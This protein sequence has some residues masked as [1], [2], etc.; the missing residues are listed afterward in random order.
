MIKLT[1]ILKEVVQDDPDISLLSSLD[2]EI[3]QA[4]EDTPQNEIIGTISFALAVPGIVNAIIKI[5][6]AISKKSGINLKKKNDRAWYVLL[7]KM[8][9]KIDSY[10]DAPFRLILTPFIKDPTKRDKVAKLLKAVTL[11]IV[12]IMGAVDLKQLTN[13]VSAIKQLAPETASELLQAAAEHAGPKIV[14]IIKNL[15]TSIKL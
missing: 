1:D 13:T 10:V 6:T 15:L 5:V 2:D 12:A 4:L 9:E 3:K 11:T 7:E 14:P 8:T